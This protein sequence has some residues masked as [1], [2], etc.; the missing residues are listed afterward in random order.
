MET[1]D[2]EA[3]LFGNTPSDVVPDLQTTVWYSSGAN[4]F[5]YPNQSKPATRWEEQIDS[6]TTNLIQSLDD[7]VRKKAS[8]QVQE[9]WMREMP[10][11]ATVAPDILSGW[12]NTLGNI[13]PSILIPYLLWNVEELT[14]R[15][16]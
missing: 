2:Y 5:W 15:T 16:R 13:Q 7:A 1:F 14:K 8:F 10:A 12:R 9:I 11:I 6:L 4:H 3:V